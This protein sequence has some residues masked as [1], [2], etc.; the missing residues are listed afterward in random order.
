MKHFDI[1]VSGRVQGV[2]F[3]FM[4]VEAARRYHIRGFVKNLWNG[5]VY[6][7]AEGE[8]VDLEDFFRW[9]RTGPLGARV[10]NAET[11]E[12]TLKHYVSFEIRYSSEIP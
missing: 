12:G 4:A 2:G 9:C 6:I 5:S 3:R 10:E 7:E 11:T 1:R 8:E